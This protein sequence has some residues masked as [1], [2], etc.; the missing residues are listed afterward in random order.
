VVLA[1]PVQLIEG[2]P[3]HRCLVGDDLGWCERGVFNA[4][5]KKRRG[6]GRSASPTARRNNLTELVDRPVQ[7]DL[8]AAVLD[9]LR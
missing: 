5:V 2:S 1:A 6:A 7:G 4:G 9:V 3:V 8:P